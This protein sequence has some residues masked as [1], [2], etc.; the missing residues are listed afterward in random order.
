M[1]VHKESDK[2]EILV[3]MVRRT[4]GSAKIWWINPKQAV[5]LSGDG[6]RIGEKLHCSEPALGDV[7]ADFMS[8]IR[9]LQ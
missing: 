6:T 3:L 8:P 9:L 2:F 7:D 5:W 4:P 1:R